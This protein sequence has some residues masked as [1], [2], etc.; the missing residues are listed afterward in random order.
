MKR[1][2]D[3]QIEENMVVRGEEEGV[4][5]RV[6]KRLVCVCQAALRQIGYF[7]RIMT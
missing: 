5:G 3:P 2:T 7:A 4:S 6:P 1:I